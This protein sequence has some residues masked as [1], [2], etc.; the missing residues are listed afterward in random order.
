V[1]VQ[2]NA[3]MKIELIDVLGHVLKS[4]DYDQMPQGINHLSVDVAT[5]PPGIYYSKVYYNEQYYTDKIV[6]SK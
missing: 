5:L 1:N 4:V 2:E 6:I 3:T